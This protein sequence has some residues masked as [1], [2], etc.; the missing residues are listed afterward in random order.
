MIRFDE[1]L[2][3]IGSQAGPLG[4][5]AVPLAQAAGRILASDCIAQVNAPPSDVS[6]M[7]GYALRDEDLVRSMP[8]RVVGVAYPGSA[9]NGQLQSLECVRVFTGAPIPKGADRVVIQEE[10]RR[11]ADLAI[12]LDPSLVKR[13]I[14][15]KGLDFAAGDILLRKGRLLD[16]RSLVAAAGAD[17]AELSV[18]RRPRVMVMST[19]DELVAPGEARTRGLAI[20]ESGSFGVAAMAQSWGAEVIDRQRVRDDIDAMKHTALRAMEACDL[21]IVTGGASVGEKDYAKRVFTELGA[22]IL[23]S[24]VAIMPGKP[25][26]LGRRGDVLILGLPGNPSSAMVTARLFLSSLLAGMTGRG[27][28]EAVMWRT[29]T[30]AESLPGAGDRE[31]FVRAIMGERGVIAVSNQDSGMQLALADA[32]LL[33]RRLPRA[34]ALEPGDPIEVIDF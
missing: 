31:T 8:F 7:D 10:I 14:R 22:D 24:K 34:P 21:V 17:L 25:V 18:W 19:G 32:T 5:E 26:W 28:A 16:P 15:S 1:A 2:A 30:L 4:I 11:E 20:P 27:V 9:F 3:I 12:V 13:H 6:A 33:V 23:F 29:A